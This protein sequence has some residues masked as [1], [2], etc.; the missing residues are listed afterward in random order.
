VLPL[1]ALLLVPSSRPR[2]SCKR[3]GD[4]LSREGEGL[5]RSL[6]LLGLQLPSFYMSGH[7][8]SSTKLPRGCRRTAL[9]EAS[10]ASTVSAR[11]L[12]PRRLSAP[13]RALASP[14]LLLQTRGHLFCSVERFGTLAGA[15]SDR[16]SRRAVDLLKLSRRRPSARC[17]AELALDLS[18]RR[19]RSY[20]EELTQ[21]ML[22]ASL[23]RAVRP[24]QPTVMRKSEVETSSNAF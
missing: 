3:E 14:L 11:A 12:G 23:A 24:A 18:E 4:V 7:S 10:D 2:E 22:R 8:S 17:A 20:N 13:S 1:L 21:R 6:K 16:K 19:T 15:R 9:L 5:Q